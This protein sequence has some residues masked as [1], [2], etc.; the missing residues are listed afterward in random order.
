[1]PVS[2]EHHPNFVYWQTML[3]A[4]TDGEIAEIIGAYCMQRIHQV[5]G[6]TI[7][8]DFAE[9]VAQSDVF[10]TNLRCPGIRHTCVMCR[11][12]W[13]T[14]QTTSLNER[15]T[16]A[17]PACNALVSP[18]NTLCDG[19][20][21]YIAPRDSA[22]EGYYFCM[23]DLCPIVISECRECHLPFDSESVGFR[24]MGCNREKCNK[25]ARDPTD[26]CNLTVWELKIICD[27]KL[28]IACLQCKIRTYAD[29]KAFNQ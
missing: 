27:R 23:R 9:V 18:L 14:L 26:L 2:I 4:N 12:G 5:A 6:R 10:A 29:T 22:F 17:C 13:S 15:G 24:C 1:M 16:F 20:T 8:M 21:R 7:M 3:I 25:C 28:T 19:D 11:V